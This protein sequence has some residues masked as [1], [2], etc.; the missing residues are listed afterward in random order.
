MIG[1]CRFLLRRRVVRRLLVLTLFTTLLLV[2]EWL[3]ARRL[4]GSGTTGRSVL[5][6]AAAGSVTLAVAI[7]LRVRLHRRLRVRRYES[8]LA[9]TPRGFEEEIGRL[10]ASLGY[11]QVQRVGGPGDLGADLI[12]R[13][14]R[15]KHVVVQC[16]RYAPGRRV[17]SADIQAFIGMIT[18]HHQ[19]DRGLFVTTS[20]FTAPALDLARQHGVE[21]FDGERLARL[22][23]DRR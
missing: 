8:L 12:C 23:A 7:W 18:V 20:A 3:L 13:D 15:R 14:R 4:F 6:A 17:G 11:S 19:A 1:V 10:L 21:L 16:K 9:L 5:G 2:A 22:I